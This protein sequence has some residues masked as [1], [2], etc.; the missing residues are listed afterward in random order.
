MKERPASGDRVSDTFLFNLL[1]Y[2]FLL[3][4]LRRSLGSLEATRVRNR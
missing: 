1:F 3:L 4:F 2:F